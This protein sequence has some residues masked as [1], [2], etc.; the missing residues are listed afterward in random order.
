MPSDG[1]VAIGRDDQ[2]AVRR[3]V[4]APNNIG[5]ARPDLLPHGVEQPQ[6]HVTTEHKPI[7]SRNQRDAAAT[8][9]VQNELCAIQLRGQ[10][11]IPVVRLIPVELGSRLRQRAARAGIDGDGPTRKVKTEHALGEPVPDRP[12]V[13]R[14]DQ[15]CGRLLDPD[16]RRCF[17]GP[18]AAW[19]CRRRRSGRILADPRKTSA[20]RLGERIHTTVFCLPATSTKR[21]RRPCPSAGPTEN[22]IRN[23]GPF[24]KYPLAIPRPRDLYPG[25]SRPLTVG[26]VSGLKSR[27][28]RMATVALSKSP[29]AT[30]RPSGENATDNGRPT[31]FTLVF[32]TPVCH[33]DPA[34]KAARTRHSSRK[35]SGRRGR[36]Q[37]VA[38]VAVVCVARQRSI[39]IATSK[40]RMPFAPAIAA[41]RRLPSGEKAKC[42][43]TLGRP[44]NCCANAPE[45]RSN[46]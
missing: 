6:G 20:G 33:I 42:R 45:A 32:G 2:F 46:K 40:T 4:D 39:P 30:W 27:S 44:G 14:A 3:D 24:G 35:P 37:A 9:F 41:A 19:P 23:F 26:K 34:R 25:F 10:A 1:A 7:G 13:L 28:L 5:A 29:T 43:T 36:N 15:K 16:G 17:P 18:A 38:I 8:S 22:S 21:Q 12:F 11:I 31:S